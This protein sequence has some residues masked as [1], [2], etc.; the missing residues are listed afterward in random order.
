MIFTGWGACLLPSFATELTIRLICLALNGLVKNLP[1]VAHEEL[2]QPCTRHMKIIIPHMFVPVTKPNWDGVKSGDWKSPS[3]PFIGLITKGCKSWVPFNQD[4]VPLLHTWA[5]TTS[6]THMDKHAH[7]HAG[8]FPREAGGDLWGSVAF[9]KSAV[10]QVVSQK[11]LYAKDFLD[12][13]GG[14][15]GES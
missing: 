10:P 1:G 13:K 9:A 14:G 3:T 7:K 12:R 15:G 4:L 6:F 5:F 2:F 11:H 8:A